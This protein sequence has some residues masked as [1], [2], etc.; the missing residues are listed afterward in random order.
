MTTKHLPRLYV[1][2]PDEVDTQRLLGQL[3]LALKG[4][5]ALVQYRNKKADVALR[6][7]QAQAIHRLCR[8]HD[9][10][11]IINDHLD[12]ALQINAE[13]LHLGGD[14]GDLVAARAALGPDKWLGASCYNRLELA[15]QALAAGASYVA[16]GAMF[17]S[18]TKPN[19]VVA[20]MAVLTQAQGLFNCPICA[21]GGITAENIGQVRA[22][23]ADWVAVIGS[24]F[25]ATDIAAATQNL[26]AG[27]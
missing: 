24:V 15:Q 4:G 17:S 27:L 25:Q 26:V 16:F 20:E 11:L 14:D 21:I 1:I 2:T 7:E 22:A 5:A 6:L 3:E 18:S 12:L 9:V 19:A 10:P 23:G 8:E 13:G